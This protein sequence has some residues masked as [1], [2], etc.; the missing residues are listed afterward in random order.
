MQGSFV[1]L[2]PSHS[3]HSSTNH[4][5]LPLTAPLPQHILTITSFRL[6]VQSNNVPTSLLM[7]GKR[8]VE[9]TFK[10]LSY[11]IDRAMAAS[12][13]RTVNPFEHQPLD[14]T[15][16]EIRL[17]RLRRS[18]LL[19]RNLVIEIQHFQL[20]EAPPYRAISY[21]W[22]TQAAKRSLQVDGKALAIG[23]NLHEFLRTHTTELSQHHLWADQICIHQESTSERNHQVQF[24][25]MIYRQAEEVLVWLGPSSYASAFA[26]TTKRNLSG[27]FLALQAN[28][29]VPKMQW[30]MESSNLSQK[31][32]PFRPKRRVLK[33]SECKALAILTDNP[34]WLRHW[35]LQEIFLARHV[36]IYY[37]KMVL[38]FADV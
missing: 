31:L 10:A 14:T 13:V 30:D 2:K 37:D 11:S 12:L 21:H 9:P 19:Q 4:R 22:G 27:K 8:R 26:T 35:I 33:T 18:S 34:Y 1:V 7:A 25:H 5:L 15:R 3:S 28:D 20:A 36:R 16:N 38:P 29:Q 32:L 24:M 6:Q 23:Q 17:F